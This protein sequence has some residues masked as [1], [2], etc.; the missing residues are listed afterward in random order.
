MDELATIKRLIIQGRYAFTEKALTEIDRDH[1]TE[2]LVIESI[3]N[4][5]FMKVKK[6][7]SPY[8]KHKDE[9]V[10][11]IESF[12]YSGLLLY[13]K[14]VVKKESDGDKFYLLISSKRSL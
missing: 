10:Y 12:T 3:L 7:I 1:L 13:T 2:E 11:I 14:G 6:T 4:A 9:R 5:Q 8:K